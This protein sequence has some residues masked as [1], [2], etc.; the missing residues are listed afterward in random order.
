[1]FVGLRALGLQGLA[2]RFEG[3][4]SRV[5]VVRF[6]LVLEEFRARRVSDAQR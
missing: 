2:V 6:F 3:P 1:M 5:R 4:G